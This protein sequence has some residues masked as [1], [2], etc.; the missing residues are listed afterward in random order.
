MHSLPNPI[1]ILGI[2][3]IVYMLDILDSQWGKNRKPYEGGYLVMITS[4]I[5][6]DNTDYLKALH[7][8]NIQSPQLAEF[9]DQYQSDCSDIVWY[10]QLFIVSD[11]FNL[12]IAYFKEKEFQ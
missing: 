8:H 11:D 3:E 5:N 4:P 10:I 1:P 7:K 9:T 2:D 6:I 12:I